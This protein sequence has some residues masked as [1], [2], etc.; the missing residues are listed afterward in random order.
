VREP[1]R[2][3]GS[4]RAADVYDI[5]GGRVLRR[6]R[7]GA[8]PEVV[9]REVTVMRHVRAHGYPVPHVFDADGTDVVMERLDGVTMLDDLSTRP[10]RMPRHADTWAHLHRRLRAVPVDGLTESIEPRFGPPDSILHLDFHPLNIMLTS[11]G[12]V[13]FDWTNAALGPAAAD[14]GLAWVISATSTIDVPAHL[15]PVAT[16]MRR[17][18]VDRFVDS[19]GRAAAIAILPAVADYRLED[20]NTRPEEAERVRQLV[21][22]VRAAPRPTGGY[23]RPRD[24]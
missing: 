6:Y 3:I 13:V 4:G 11:D 16:W 15:R 21:S 12:P 10:W 20:R 17:R 5:G 2:L 1:G 7:I 19:C 9:A 22:R 24:M 14:V 8:R 18:F 23:S